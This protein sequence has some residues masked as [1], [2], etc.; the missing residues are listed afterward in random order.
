MWS[1]VHPLSLVLHYPMEAPVVPR[2]TIKTSLSIASKYWKIFLLF[3]FFF[4]FLKFQR[5]WLHE[6]WQVYS[7]DDPGLTFTYMYFTSWSKLVP[8]VF[9]WEC[10][11]CRFARN[12]SVKPVMWKLVH[13]VNYMSTMTTQGQ[14][15][16]L[17]LRFDIFKL[18][19]LKKHLG[20]LKPNSLWSLH[21]MLGWKFIQ[22]FRITWPRWLPIPY[23]VKTLK[24][25]LLRNQEAGD[26]ETW[27][28][29]SSTQV[30]PNWFKWWHW[31]DLV[32][33]LWYGQICSLMLLQGSKLIQHIVI[34][35][36]ACSYSAHPMHSGERYRTNGS[37][38]FIKVGR[39]HCFGR[40]KAISIRTRP[41]TGTSL[42][43]RSK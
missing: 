21:G 7:N 2:E 16:S 33:F 37:L 17:T 26:I 5:H 24:N 20:R 14:G 38:V 32:H 11:R 6:Y 13:I 23:M 22:L 25:V 28:K 27:Y 18:L 1:F 40:G 12:C 31:V 36:Q 3:F 9:V 15:H 10:L 39:A 29:A 41:Y 34:Y 8:F 19:F 42:F 35:F 30:L 43:L 4:F